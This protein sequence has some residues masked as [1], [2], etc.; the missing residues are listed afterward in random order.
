M[1]NKLKLFFIILGGCVSLYIAMTA[2]AY[3]NIVYSSWKEGYN[4]SLNVDNRRSDGRFD[5]ILGVYN[6]RW[7]WY[8]HIPCYKETIIRDSVNP[9]HLSNWNVISVKGSVINL[10]NNKQVILVKNTCKS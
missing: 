1:K 9:E 5:V 3:V 2:S 8:L 10:K 7:R 4:I 6:S